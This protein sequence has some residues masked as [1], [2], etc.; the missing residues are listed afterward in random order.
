MIVSILAH[1]Y[2]TKKACYGL[3]QIDQ[4]VDEILKNR[5]TVRKTALSTLS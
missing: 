3:L 4:M 1:T 2:L 5:R